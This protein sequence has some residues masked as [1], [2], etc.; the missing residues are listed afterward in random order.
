MVAL[1]ITPIIHIRDHR[2]ARLV[3][4]LADKGRAGFMHAQNDK[5]LG[6]NTVP[7]FRA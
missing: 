6:Q 1:V 2:N 7:G 4:H 5:G 3:K